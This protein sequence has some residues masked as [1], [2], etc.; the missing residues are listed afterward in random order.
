MFGQLI[1]VLVLGLPAAALALPPAIRARSPWRFFAAVPVVIFGI[2]LPLLVFLLSALLVPEWR[3]ACPHG[4]I[5]AFPLGKLA[6][7]PIVLWATAALYATDVMRVSRPCSPW[8]SA[9]LLS[10]ALTSTACLAFGVLTVAIE[11]KLALFL[12][13]PAWTCAWYWAR[14]VEVLRSGGARAAVR[15]ALLASLPL[16]A[17][18]L[19]WSR[20]RYASLPEEP[21]E[22]LVVQQSP[23]AVG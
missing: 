22:C 6:L 4:W 11:P 2:L 12:V 15:T 5:D 10:G 9:G 23:S 1:L 7:T 21:P 20:A 17:A 19:L 8:I 18:S 3:G 14:S 13:V 16:L